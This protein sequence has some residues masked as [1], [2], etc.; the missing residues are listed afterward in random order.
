MASSA[1]WRHPP[2]LSNHINARFPRSCDPSLPRPRTCKGDMHSTDRPLPRPGTRGLHARAPRHAA[3]QHGML[4]CRPRCRWRVPL[5]TRAWRHLHAAHGPCACT[6]MRVCC[7]MRMGAHLPCP[8]S[9]TECRTKPMR[10]GAHAGV[11]RLLPMEGPLS[12]KQELQ[13][14]RSIR[15]DFLQLGWHEGTSRRHIGTH[16]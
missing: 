16:L 14:A 9:C 2:R 7:G 11:P 1:L 10:C 4:L 3:Q 12:H 8:A 5:A 13:A 6:R 15:W